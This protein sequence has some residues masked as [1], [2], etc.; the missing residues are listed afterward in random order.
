PF[1]YRELEY[2]VVRAR[3]TGASRL[4]PASETDA[5]ALEFRF[6]SREPANNK[7]YGRHALQGALAARVAANV[8]SLLT[9]GT[10][11]DGRP[12]SPRHI[13]VLTRT[14]KEAF[15]CQRA[16]AQLRIPSV[17]QGDRSV[18]EQPEARELQFVLAAAA[19]PARNSTIRT[20]LATELL[21][22]S[23][24]DLEGL[25]ADEECWDGW[26]ERFQR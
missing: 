21:G 6:V 16:L 23:A 24:N 14:N 11:L 9:A 20:A 17:V 26:V 19:E 5:G 22:L 2:P 4:N 15:D 3:H 10:Y 7:P 8:R 1:L 13:A 12:L 25:E 18:F